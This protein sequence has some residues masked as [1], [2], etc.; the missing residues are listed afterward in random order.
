MFSGFFEKSYS[1][2]WFWTRVQTLFSIFVFLL[3]PILMNHTPSLLALMLIGGVVLFICA[4]VSILK[5]IP[6]IGVYSEAV[7]VLKDHKNKDLFKYVSRVSSLLKVIVM[8]E[9]VF[10]VVW[11]ISLIFKLMVDRYLYQIRYFIGAVEIKD[12]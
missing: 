10:P 5:I 3:V 12:D 4:L 9:L 6:L 8:M 1:L 11:P 7:K 2:I